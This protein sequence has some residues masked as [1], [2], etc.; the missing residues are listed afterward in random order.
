MKRD[1]TESTFKVQSFNFTFESN[2]AFNRRSKLLLKAI[3]KSF[4]DARIIYFIGIM[5]IASVVIADVLA[6]RMWY[7]CPTRM[8]YD[9]NLQVE[10]FFV[11]RIRCFT[12]FVSILCNILEF[13]KIFSRI[14]RTILNQFKWERLIHWWNLLQE[15]S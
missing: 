9:S 12:I 6:Y 2:E 7:R 1:L 5:L 8:S 11:F 14:S 4:P 15:N 13:L 3:L 10:H